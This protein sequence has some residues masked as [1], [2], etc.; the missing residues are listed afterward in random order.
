M[1]A[2]K[3]DEYMSDCKFNNHHKTIFIATY[4]ENI[5]LVAYIVSRRKINLYV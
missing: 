1:S 3:S 4:V 5:M 2:Y